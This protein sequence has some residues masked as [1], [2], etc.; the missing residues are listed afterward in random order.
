MKHAIIAGS[1]LLASSA[2]FA[3]TNLVQ[4]GSFEDYTLGNGQWTVLKN[5]PTWNS[6][7]GQGFEIQRNAAGAAQN[8]NILVELDSHNLHQAHKPAN[9][10]SNSNIWQNL[11]TTVGSLYDISFWYSPRPGVATA[12]NGLK[13]FW[14]NSL[15]ASL[16]PTG[17]GL[18]QTTW[19]NWTG[20]FMAT[21]SNTKLS[22]EAFGAEDTRG[23]YLDNVSVTL[24]QVA[25]VPEPETYALMGLG[26]VGLLAARRRKFA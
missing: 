12:S 5:T 19:T 3:A 2:S 15:I 7:S 9:F 1:L 6:T 10:H 4:N 17:S 21:A 25:P 24:H 20:T 16:Q 11:N 8:G 26:L 23:T 13:A 18:N 22:F 14:G